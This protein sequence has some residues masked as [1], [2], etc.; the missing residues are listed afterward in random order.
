M[1]K[2][3]LRPA[4]VLAIAWLLVSM[5]MSILLVPSLGARGLI[6]LGIQDAACLFGCG[7]EMR[8]AW[9][10]QL[11]LRDMSDGS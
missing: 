3:V 8:R 11:A 2:R 4:L 6:W 10:H 5:V 9:R 7:W 1:K